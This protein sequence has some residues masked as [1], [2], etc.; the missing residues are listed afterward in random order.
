[1]V[2][3]T[4]A[5]AATGTPSD[6]YRLRDGVRRR[7]D[8]LVAL[9]PLTVSRLNGSGRAIADALSRTSFAT[10]ESL[11]AETGQ[12]VE[13]VAPFLDRLQD[14]GFL[15][16]RPGRDDS[17]RPPV[18]VVVTVRNGS[19]HLEGCLD[20]LAALTYADYEVVLVDDGSTDGTVEQ[21]HSHRLSRTGTLRVI[22]VG[23]PEDPLGIGTSRNRGVDA[24]THDVVA[25]TDVDCRPSPT[26]LDDLVPYLAGADIVGGRVRPHGEACLSGY[27]RLH[28]SLDMGTRPGHV[29]PES[30]T[31][32]LPTA[33]L[34]ASRE[35][36]ETVEFPAQ[37][38]G[39]DV[40]FCWHAVDADFEVVY[41]PTGPV[42][43][44]YRRPLAAFSSRRADY[45]RSEALLS[46]PSPG[47]PAVPLPLPSGLLPVLVLSAT[48]GSETW[49][50]GALL[51]AVVVGTAIGTRDA[52]AYLGIRAAVPAGT[53]LGSRVR[54]GVSSVYAVAS[55]TSRYYSLPLGTVACGCALAGAA[56]IA[57][58]IGVGLAFSIAY[59]TVI[60]YLVRRPGMSVARYVLL[61]VIDDLSYQVGAYRGALRY[62]SVGHLAPW[63]R[64]SVTLA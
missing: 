45:G 58:A 48:V 5:E 46:R 36:V 56:T 19:A 30:G 57:T 15:D 64:F 44:D 37:N 41:V 35:V 40:D 17:A 60:D 24:A 21:A 14:R 28:S 12:P 4:A 29:D 49:R 2:P 26:W 31:P 7:G 3:E 27:E 52:L 63:N 62:R 33:N 22:E 20:A 23:A 42:G 39:E 18:S 47:G 38:V 50:L 11:A 34:V 43:H 54:A 25:F 6:R 13:T 10:P 8:L 61:S 55:E 16:W 32:Y 53:Y 59:P 1:M 9:R 51:L